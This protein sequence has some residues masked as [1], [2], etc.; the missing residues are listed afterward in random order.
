MRSCTSFCRK[1]LVVDPRIRFHLL[2]GAPQSSKVE[3]LG[4]VLGNILR[5]EFLTDRY[6]LQLLFFS[7]GSPSPDSRRGRY[8]YSVLARWPRPFLQLVL[9]VGG[10]HKGA[11]LWV[12]V[13]LCGKRVEEVLKLPLCF[14]YRFSAK[15]EHPV[16]QQCLA[17]E[18][19]GC[20]ATAV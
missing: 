6:I 10:V 13:T 2:D 11:R 19:I 1:A 9:L 14:P 17:P 5:E 16:T 7:T 3:D 12:E 8:S 20:M 4:N 15:V 18:I